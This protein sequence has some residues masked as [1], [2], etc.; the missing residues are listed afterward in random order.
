MAPGYRSDGNMR[1]W[2][3]M[4][5]EVFLERES[6]RERVAFCPIMYSESHAV[7]PCIP[8]RRITARSPGQSVL[9]TSVEM[10]A[11]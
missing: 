1:N 9:S 8:H 10:S 7:N 4:H 3:C 2:N 6:L 11:I 5:A